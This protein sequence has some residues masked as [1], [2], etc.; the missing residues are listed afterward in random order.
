MI[1][2]KDNRNIVFLFLNTFQREKN[3]G[4]VVNKFLQNGKYPLNVF[5]DTKNKEDETVFD[6]GTAYNVTE[7]P[8]KSNPGLMEI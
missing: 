6:V 8:T 4:E 3:R 1:K 7:I 2:Y 5:Y